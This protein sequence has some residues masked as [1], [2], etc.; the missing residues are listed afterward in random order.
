MPRRALESLTEPMY[1]V[2]MA[3]R[4]RPMCGIDVMSYIQQKTHGQVLLGPATLYTILG[5]FEKEGYLRETAVDGRK[6]TYQITPAGLDA[7]DAEL[8]RL[9]RCILDAETEGEET[10]ER[11]GPQTGLALSPVPGL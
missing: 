7:F 5:K 2:L 1:Y 9:K 6:R 3:F 10:H 11:Y 8:D 4:A